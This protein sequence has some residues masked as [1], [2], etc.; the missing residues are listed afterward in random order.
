MVQPGLDEGDRPES[1][2]TKTA[3]EQLWDRP[4]GFITTLA[5]QEDAIVTSDELGCIFGIQLDSASVAC[6]LH[7][8]SRSC[9]PHLLV[10]TK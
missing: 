2:H 7:R 9:S 3:A 5:Q 1:K 4:D 8:V 6:N 10:L